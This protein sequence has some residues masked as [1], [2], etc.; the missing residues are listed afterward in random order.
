MLPLFL[1]EV[2]YS[3]VAL[4][5]TYRHGLQFENSLQGAA[6]SV[7]KHRPGKDSVN[8]LVDCKE[9]LLLHLED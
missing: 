4:W 1:L 2:Q 7:D 6:L 3:L 5:D 8:L 9:V